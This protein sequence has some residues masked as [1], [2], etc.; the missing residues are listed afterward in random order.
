MVSGE[1]KQTDVPNND[2]KKVNPAY[3]E[4]YKRFM[5]DIY[6]YSGEK[7]SITKNNELIN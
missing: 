1:Q 4:Y 7:K 6:L 5:S 3:V 2:K